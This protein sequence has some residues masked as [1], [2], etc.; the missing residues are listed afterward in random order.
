MRLRVL[1]QHLIAASALL[2]V[3]A[4]SE[5]GEA[6]QPDPTDQLA[7]Q[8]TWDRGYISARTFDGN[9]VR[10]KWRLIE[11][12]YENFCG[13]RARTQLH[14]DLPPCADLRD[15][16]WQAWI[17]RPGV[18]SISFMMRTAPADNEYL[19]SFTCIAAT[20]MWAC[21]TGSHELEFSVDESEF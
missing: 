1:A 9:L 21:G 12:A 6:F 19:A 5:P 3:A 8:D 2:W 18:V 10:V 4:C 14:P 17:E 20:T 15:Y 7:Q 13:T 16:H 11:I